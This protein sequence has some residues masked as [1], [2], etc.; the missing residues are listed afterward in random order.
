MDS[1][2][3]K[4]YIKWDLKLSP[5]SNGPITLGE[6]TTISWNQHTQS[7]FRDTH[8]VLGSLTFA[9]SVT[10][11]VIGHPIMPSLVELTVAFH[12]PSFEFCKAFLT[13]FRPLFI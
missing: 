11:A 2:A 8:L 10:A 4:T 12:L 3:A 9:G 13:S 7:L 6:E 1:G 5:F